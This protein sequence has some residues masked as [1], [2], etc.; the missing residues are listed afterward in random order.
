MNPIKKNALNILK[1][2]TEYEIEKADGEKIGE[3]TGLSSYQD[4][5]D[6][7][8]YMEKIDIADIRFKYKRTPPYYFDHIIINANGR[9]L[10]HDMNE[11]KSDKGTNELLN[12]LN[13][14]KD[15]ITKIQEIMEKVSTGNGFYQEYDK[16][17]KTLYFSIDSK[18]NKLNRNKHKIEITQHNKFISLQDFYDYWKVNL[19]SYQKRRAYIRSLYSSLELKIHK[20]LIKIDEDKDYRNI[21]VKEMIIREHI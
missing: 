3:L 2:M 8:S 7:V 13:E 15:D 1:I 4:I 12:V 16:E 11:T 21:E 5:N 19:D 14:L 9:I 20:L 18:I 17:Y 6:A 10:Y